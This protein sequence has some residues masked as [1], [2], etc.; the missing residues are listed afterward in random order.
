MTSTRRRPTRRDPNAPA[1]RALAEAKKALDRHRESLDAARRARDGSIERAR[2]SLRG[3]KA[4]LA[5]AVD[6]RRKGLEIE[7][8]SVERF[9]APLRAARPHARRRHEADVPS[10]DM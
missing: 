5:N 10:K 8:K 9:D 1:V 4:S 6:G 3:Y 2:D 7:M